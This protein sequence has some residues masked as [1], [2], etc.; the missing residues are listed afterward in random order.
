MEGRNISF[1]GPMRASTLYS[2]S[3]LVYLW[4]LR[5]TPL[6]MGKATFVGANESTLPSPITADLRATDSNLAFTCEVG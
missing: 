2:D 5:S 4:R 6:L 1:S 3:T